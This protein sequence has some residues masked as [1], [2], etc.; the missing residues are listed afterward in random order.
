MADK[1]TTDVREWP[2]VKHAMTVKDLRALLDSPALDGRLDHIV[3]LSKDS[4]GNDFSPLTATDGYSLGF[5]LPHREK[6][7][8]SGSFEDPSSYA[9]PD[10]D[11]HGPP[12]TDE[13]VPALCLWPTN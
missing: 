10:S 6:R 13:G 5:Y 4:E 8:Y 12:G 2:A 9:D 3:V 7:S 11:R 1:I